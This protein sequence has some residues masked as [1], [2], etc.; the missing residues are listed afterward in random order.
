[1]STPVVPA[2]A[3]S[4]MTVAEVRKALGK[5]RQMWFHSTPQ[6]PLFISEI[7]VGS[8]T[9][10]DFCTEF[11]YGHHLKRHYKSAQQEAPA[12]RTTRHEAVD[13][14]DVKDPAAEGGLMW[15]EV[16][17]ECSTKSAS[18]MELW[19]QQPNVPYSNRLKR[20]RARRS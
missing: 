3:V 6:N 4:G 9:I 1:M 13:A 18:P 14:A 5:I 16:K 10:A 19:T 8:K 11:V 7:L 20:K 2:S 12:E 17:P 15:W